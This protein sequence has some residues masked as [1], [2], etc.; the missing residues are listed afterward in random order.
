MPLHSC[1]AL[2]TPYDS[3]LVKLVKEGNREHIHLVTKKEPVSP[4]ILSAVV[5]KFGPSDASLYNVSICCIFLL[6]YVR[7][8][9]FSEIELTLSLTNSTIDIFSHSTSLSMYYEL[10]YLT[11]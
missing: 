4:D 6:R 7:F 9:R 3:T 1:K 11:Y 8:W 5:G 2:S 10:V